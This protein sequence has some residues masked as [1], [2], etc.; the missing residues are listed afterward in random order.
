MYDWNIQ[1]KV[2]CHPQND[3][4]EQLLDHGKKSDFFV[5]LNLIFKLG[6]LYRAE[7][8]SSFLFQ[9][10]HLTGTPL[11]EKVI[12]RRVDCEWADH[13]YWEKEDPQQRLMKHQ[14]GNWIIFSWQM[15]L[16]LTIL[17]KQSDTFAFP[18]TKFQK[19]FRNS[20]LS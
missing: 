7:I 1:R 16:M 3:F 19:R 6:F 17:F 18:Y 5:I 2:W 9:E 20:N 12:Y 10:Y 8:N 13:C 15:S 14:N 4:H 11:C